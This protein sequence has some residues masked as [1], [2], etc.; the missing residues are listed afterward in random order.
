MII[1]IDR[2]GP[3]FSVSFILQRGSKPFIGIATS[4]DTY[5]F[6]K[7]ASLE[8]QYKLTRQR[9]QPCSMAFHKHV[10]SVGK[11]SQLSQRRLDLRK[12]LAERGKCTLQSVGGHPFFD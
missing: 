3:C 1:R 4:N 6:V 8:I 5:S 12:L 10:L 2:L 9:F 11:N 7:L